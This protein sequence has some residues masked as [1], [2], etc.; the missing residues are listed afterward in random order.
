[1]GRRN[2]P[3]TLSR[4]DYLPPAFVHQ[5]VVEVAEGKQVG[6]VAFSAS[7]PEFDVMRA[8]PVD[9]PVAAW[10]C[11]AAVPS[12][13]GSPLRRRDRPRRPADIDHN[14]V[15]LENPTQGS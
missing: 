14:R 4:A 6:Q 8:G 13:E 10:G 2:E 3:H 15:R 5:P 7:R 1:M 11:T 9:R 12:L